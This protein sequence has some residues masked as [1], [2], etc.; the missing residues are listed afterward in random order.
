MYVCFY[1]RMKQDFLKTKYI[2]N[3]IELLNCKVHAE[4]WKQRPNN[5]GCYAVS[6]TKMIISFHQFH[7]LLTVISTNFVV[8]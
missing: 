6:E 2:S 5:G 3:L 4:N 1:R 8:V 7:I